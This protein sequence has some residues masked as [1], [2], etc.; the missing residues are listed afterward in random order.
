MPPPSHSLALSPQ[1]LLLTLPK[2]PLRSN[3]L[4]LSSLVFFRLSRFPSLSIT[5]KSPVNSSLRPAAGRSWGVRVPVG[6]SSPWLSGAPD[7]FKIKIRGKHIKPLFEV[8]APGFLWS[9]GSPARPPPQALSD[10]AFHALM[11]QNLSKNTH[12]L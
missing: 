4:A 12:A 1:C 10:P 8:A 2:P 11:L 6:Q 9:A 5:H 7:I 3:Q